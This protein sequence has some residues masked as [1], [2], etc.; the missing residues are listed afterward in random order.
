[1]EHFIT[2]A[3][4]G[5]EQSGDTA[6]TTGTR[7]DELSNQLG[8][9]G[10]ERQLLLTAAAWGAYQ[11]AGHIAE[12]A[13]ELPTPAQSESKDWHPLQRPQI[14]ETLLA[15][16]EKALLQEALGYMQERRC[17]V[18]YDLLPVFLETI[19]REK[20]LREQAL[21]LLGERGCWLSRHNPKWN[22]AY[23]GLNDKIVLSVEQLESTWQEGTL[24]Q[25][26]E[27][28]RQQRLFDPSTARQWLQH[29]WKK[30]RV[31]TRAPLLEILALNLSPND[32]TFLEQ[33]LDDRSEQIRVI[34]ARLLAMLPSS[35]FIQR[36][37]TY[38][39]ALL[40]YQDGKISVHTP[41]TLDKNWVRDGLFP[42]VEN[43]FSSINSACQRILEYLPFTY[44]EEHFSLS[45]Q[46][47]LANMEDELWQHVLFTVLSRRATQEHHLGW[48]RSLL[49]F[50]Q[51]EEASGI[52][53][54][55]NVKAVQLISCLPQA[56]AE[57]FFK[58]MF[59]QDSASIT[60]DLQVLPPPWS[61]EFSM[62]YLDWAREVARSF[63][64]ETEGGK[65]RLEHLRRSLTRA[66]LALPPSCFTLALQ[67]WELHELPEKYEYSIYYDHQQTKNSIN[68][69]L[70]TL[71]LRKMIVEEIG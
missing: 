49:A 17:R 23:E 69:F 39:D 63:P 14:L 44:W 60:L 13:P 10:K 21:P 57:S 11:N 41:A 34:A 42:K 27:A 50:W 66:A 62:F 30:E 26:V 70:E 40:N 8:E 3:I 25:R 2:A 22:W 43:T 55:L 38:A 54:R 5:T 28:L 51:G 64:I 47:L 9:G 29:A 12:A 36:M 45:P 6:L 4:V 67:E 71:H 56:E 65:A 20:E 15:H 59:R 68:H 53:R 46:Q 31:D 24:K 61:H 19:T 35:A 16:K 48:I 32:E 1:M 37:R 58:E 18:P 52:R 7:I 33:A